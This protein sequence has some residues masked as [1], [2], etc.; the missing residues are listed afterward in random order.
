MTTH[1]A[2]N[3]I[4]ETA[5]PEQRLADA[6]RHFVNATSEAEQSAAR[7]DILHAA[8]QMTFEVMG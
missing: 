3:S 1:E 4:T 8:S 2:A 7:V 6:V 5:T